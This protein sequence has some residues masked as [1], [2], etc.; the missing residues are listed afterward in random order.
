MHRYEAKIS[1]SRNG[2]K[3]LNQQYSRG[4][5]WSFDGGIKIS[6]SASPQAVR[7]PLS[8]AEAIDPEEALVAAASSCHMLFFLSR[9]SKQ[10]FVVDSYVDEPFGM[11][12]KN[13]QGKFAVTHITLRPKIQ[14]SGEKRPT[15][16]E[17][18]ALHHAAHE[19][20]YIANSLKSEVTVEAG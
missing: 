7:A 4:H 14:F 9:A 15:G 5:E 10:G 20:C 8:V 11:V 6:A 19:E 12:E 3:F 13:P 1:W 2:A 17:L 16:S 18:S